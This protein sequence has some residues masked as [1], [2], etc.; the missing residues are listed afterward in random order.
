VYAALRS[1]EKN[2]QAVRVAGVL[3]RAQERVGERV[4]V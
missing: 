1:L 4:H 2:G 3:K